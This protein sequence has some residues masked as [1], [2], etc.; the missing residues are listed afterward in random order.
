MRTLGLLTGV[1]FFL[2][3]AC[4]CVMLAG[5]S[6]APETRDRLTLVSDDGKS[7]I[8]LSADDETPGIWITREGQT[9][10]VGIYC[11]KRE[12]AVVGVRGDNSGPLDACIAVKRPRDGFLQLVSE[13]PDT[14]SPISVIRKDELVH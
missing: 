4:C 14:R 11:S 1:N 6:A 5:A 2:L 8:C 7:R 12:G 13:S 10:S 9:S 3:A